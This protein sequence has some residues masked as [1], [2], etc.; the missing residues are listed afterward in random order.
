MCVYARIKHKHADYDAHFCSASAACRLLLVSGSIS[1]SSSSVTSSAR[2]LLTEEPDDRLLPELRPCPAPAPDGLRCAAPLDGLAALDGRPCPCP[3]PL[4]G[5]PCPRPS[6]ARASRCACSLLPLLSLLRPP[7][8][9][10]P[11]VGRELEVGRVAQILA[12][13]SKKI[14]CWWVRLVWVKPQL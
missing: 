1:S 6:E 8:P 2:S 12:R 10:R 13:R 7:L 4:E 3:L 5:R 9:L 14:R 11:L